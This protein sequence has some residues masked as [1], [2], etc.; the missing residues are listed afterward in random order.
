M[1]KLRIA[2]IYP[3]SPLI[4]YTLV[5]SII[6][7]LRDQNHNIFEFNTID[8]S[9]VYNPEIALQAYEAVCSNLDLT[10]VVDLG[11]LDDE[12]L[13]HVN[14]N[15]PIVLIAG[16]NPQSFDA[17]LPQKVK[18]LIPKIVGTKSSYFGQFLGHRNT[19]L[20]YSHI[21]T[22]DLECVRLYHEKGA[23]AI[24]FP[25]W[26]DSSVYNKTITAGVSRSTDIV[27]VMNPRPNRMRE[28]RLLENSCEFL[29]SNKLN[30]YHEQAAAHY[31]SG[32]LVF[33]KSNY[34]EF[35]MRIP[36]AMAVGSML[37]TDFIS[38]AKGLYELYEPGIDLETYASQSELLDKVKFYSRKKD[39]AAKIAES[40]YRKTICNHLDVHR[41]DLLIRFT[42]ND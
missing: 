38:P 33:N 39:T 9:N 28:L 12:R 23:N 16:D 14:S 20:G 36:E 26:A 42:L 19:C 1:K 4:G 10:V 30:V 18:S 24:W 6:R 37:I 11:Y 5:H 15:H 32:F 35:T 41:A 22:S 13:Y 8:S 3:C 31:A 34:G 25:Y 27:T 7:V 29:F 40:G 2:F 21:L 17:S